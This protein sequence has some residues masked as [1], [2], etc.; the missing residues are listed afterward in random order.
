MKRFIS[1]GLFATFL[2]SVAT[3]QSFAATDRVGGPCKTINQKI[4]IETFSATCTKV[5]SKLIWKKSLGTKASSPSAAPKKK[6]ATPNPSATSPSPKTKLAPVASTQSAYAINVSTGSWF[7]NFSYLL[8]GVKGALKSDPAKSKILFLPVG[9]L[10]QL[11]LTNS[12]DVTHG[13]WIPG[14]LIDKETLPGNKANV[15]FTPDKVGT[16]PSSC[17]ISCGRGHATMTFT[18]EVVSEADYLKYLAGLK[19]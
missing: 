19:S 17:N 13:F 18:V 3:P 12:S 9:K 15:E 8:D 6:A 2:I 1:L 4:K 16:Y 10:V 7:F 14:L 5:G 11:T